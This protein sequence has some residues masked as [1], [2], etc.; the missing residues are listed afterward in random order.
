MKTW[1]LCALLGLSA[2]TAKPIALTVSPRL[3]FAPADL[4]IRLRVHAAPDDRWITVMA[5]S[6]EFYRRSGWTID[7]ACVL[8]VIQWRAL[9]AGDYDVLAQLG[10]GDVTTA[11]A[12]MSV[13]VMGAG[14]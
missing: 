5:D 7:H 6:G 3:S 10:H 4:H 11:S 9:P 13:Q 14:P 1:I 2:P 8:Y 12:R